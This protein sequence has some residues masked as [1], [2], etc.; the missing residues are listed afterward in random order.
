MR[1]F[2]ILKKNINIKK[3]KGWSQVLIVSVFDDGNIFCH[4]HRLVNDL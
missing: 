4:H 1:V 3:F 2:T